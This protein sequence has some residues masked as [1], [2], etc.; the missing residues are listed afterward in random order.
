LNF[1]T[2]IGPQQHLF[3]ASDVNSLTNTN[4]AAKAGKNEAI[5]PDTAN[6]GANSSGAIDWT[7]LST[8]SA[9]MEQALSRSDVRSDKIASLQTAITAGTYNISSADV[10]DKL[11]SGLMQ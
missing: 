1:T 2:G 5:V 10:A 8:N 9:K 3:N 4:A 11:I 7:S 6:Y